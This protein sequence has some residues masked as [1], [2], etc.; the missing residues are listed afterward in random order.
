MKLCNFSGNY[1]IK[2]QYYYDYNTTHYIY[3]CLGW[4]CKDCF[5]K[6]KFCKRLENRN[7]VCVNDVSWIQ[8]FPLKTEK[9]AFWLVIVR[10]NE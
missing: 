5:S 2:L 3:H 1:G 9:S 4:R 8:H 7:R 6:Y 10:D